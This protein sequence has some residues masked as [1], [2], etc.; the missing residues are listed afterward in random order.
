MSTRAAADTMTSTTASRFVGRAALVPPAFDGALGTSAPRAP[1]VP[2]IP[3]ALEWDT[4]EWAGG[5]APH[6]GVR[7]PGPDSMVTTWPSPSFEGLA[8][9]MATVPA[10]PA[11][12]RAP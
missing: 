6:S 8:S 9:T 2:F 10:G 11:V 7:D 5:D 3:E 1:A 4:E 12:R